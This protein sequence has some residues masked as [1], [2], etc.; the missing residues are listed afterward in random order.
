MAEIMLL[1]E[2]ARLYRLLSLL[3][4]EAGHTV[5]G[6]AP[7]L[8]VTDTKKVPQRFSS[9]PIL[10]IGEGG[11]ERPFC[12]ES[13]KARIAELL[14]EDPLPS[15]TP[16]EERLYRI[17]KEASPDFLTRETLLR[18]VFDKEDDDGR[19]NLYIHYLRKKIETDGK[20]RII[21]CRG[22]GYALLC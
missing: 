7:S 18:F 13:V 12:H 8:I 5:G 22:K 19:L 10:F 3:C 4:K 15:L 11:I 6:T 21:A 1:T 20:R 9:L 2:D 14:S 17:L 16:T